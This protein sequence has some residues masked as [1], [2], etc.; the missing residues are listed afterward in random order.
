MNN[1]ADARRCGVLIRERIIRLTAL[2]LSGIIIGCVAELDP[3]AQEPQASEPQAAIS[4]AEQRA[5]APNKAA[6][7]PA[8]QEE[9]PVAPAT[10]TVSVPPVQLLGMSREDIIRHLG[11][12]VF[13]R[14]DRTAL[15][16]RYREGRC[17]LDLYLYPRHQGEVEQAVDYFEARAD[18]GQLIETKPCID[19]VRKANASG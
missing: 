16:L 8:K 13:Q 9:P 12:P 5:P 18:D 6:T 14:R 4:T 7:E 11:K 1:H 3:A 2:L 10:K 19:A 15:L 17:I